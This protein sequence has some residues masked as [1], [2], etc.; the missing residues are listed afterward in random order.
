MEMKAV[1]S[2]IR[3][4]ERLFSLINEINRI[5]FIIMPDGKDPDDYIKENGK[6]GFLNLTKQKQIIQSFIWNNNLEK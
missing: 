5:N 4:A 3:I 1:K 6:D 2:A